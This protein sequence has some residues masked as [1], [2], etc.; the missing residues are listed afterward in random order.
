MSGRLAAI[1]EGI[2]ESPEKADP[3][4]LEGSSA[5]LMAMFDNL[6]Y[7]VTLI[8]KVQDENV[9]LKSEV[10]EHKETIRELVHQNVRGC[11]KD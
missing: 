5:Q 1:P 7:V 11:K 6:A 10:E 8:R 4:D 2:F 3:H 9:R